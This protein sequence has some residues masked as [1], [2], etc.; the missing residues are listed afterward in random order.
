MPNNNNVNESRYIQKY[1]VEGETEAVM[2][3]SGRNYIPQE[4][5]DYMN[6]TGQCVKR[7][8]ECAKNISNIASEIVSW[9]TS[10][11]SNPGS[12]D[13]PNVILSAF[14][15]DVL[16][17]E[18]TLGRMCQ[19]KLLKENQN[20]DFL[21]ENPITII[22]Q[23]VDAMYELQQLCESL[24]DENRIVLEVLDKYEHAETSIKELGFNPENF[25]YSER[26]STALQKVVSG[27]NNL[28]SNTIGG[29]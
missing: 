7:L 6:E 12:A 29:K 3:P 18:E 28:Y 22:K 16:M 4:V 25:G 11:L 14:W 2:P 9:V 21:S 17:M 10:Y 27:Y 15:K 26:I 8:E 20:I 23:F 5:I 1:V 19:D 24:K 13:M